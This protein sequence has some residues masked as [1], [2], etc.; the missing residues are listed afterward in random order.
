M[1]R[2]RREHIAE[3]ILLARKRAD[4]NQKTLADL[5]NLSPSHLSRIEKARCEP[6]QST[7]DRIAAALKVTTS[8]ILDLAD[9][10]E[11]DDERRRNKDAAYPSDHPS[12]DD[13]EV[14]E[15]LKGVTYFEDEP[16]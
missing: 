7:M 1:G 14:A 2:Q 6:R 3:A 16:E 8:V 12:R 15:R 11:R 9:Q 13:E 4:L 5:A 10:L